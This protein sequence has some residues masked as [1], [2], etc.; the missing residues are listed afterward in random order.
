MSILGTDQTFDTPRVQSITSLYG[1]L[2]RLSWIEVGVPSSSLMLHS[3]A[4][5]SAFAAD[6]EPRHAVTPMDLTFD[7]LPPTFIAAAS[8]DQFAR[9]SRICAEH[10]EQNF[11][12]VRYKLYESARHGFFAFNRPESQELLTD[13]LEFLGA[14]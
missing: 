12:D 2:D 3:Y 6:V 7:I 5:E 11:V 1:V 10:L 13:I 8:K 14:H 4:G 9:S